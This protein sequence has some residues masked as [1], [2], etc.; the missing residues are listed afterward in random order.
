MQQRQSLLKERE[1]GGGEGGGGTAS[2]GSSVHAAAVAT[3]EPS[4]SCSTLYHFA[5]LFLL[6]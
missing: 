6:P 4:T 1:G 2:L 3:G 5:L